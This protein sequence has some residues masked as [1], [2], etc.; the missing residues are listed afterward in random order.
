MEATNLLQF[1]K[2]DQK[3]QLKQ[4]KTITPKSCDSVVK[5]YGIENCIFY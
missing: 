1:A 3:T 5:G 4:V 2:Y